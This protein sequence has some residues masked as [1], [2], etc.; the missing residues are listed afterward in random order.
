MTPVLKRPGQE[1][2]CKFEVSLDYKRVRPCQKEEGG[3]RKGKKRRK[4]KRIRRRRRESEGWSRTGH[5][6]LT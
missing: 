5:C 4:K 3:R 6:L 1:D 2:C